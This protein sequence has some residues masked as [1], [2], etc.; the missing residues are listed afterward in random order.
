MDI[1]VGKYCRRWIWCNSWHLSNG[2]TYIWCSAI[3]VSVF[4]DSTLSGLFIHFRNLSPSFLTTGIL[5][6]TPSHSTKVWARWGTAGGKVAIVAPDP[7]CLLIVTQPLQQ[8]ACPCWLLTKGRLIE[9]SCVSLLPQPS[10]PLAFCTR[11]FKRHANKSKL[12]WELYNFIKGKKNE[13]VLDAI[14]SFM[15]SHC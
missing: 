7:H 5:G 11:S 14:P 2:W 12:T 15:Q 13:L 9:N 8:T 1:L 6:S 10:P 4:C 3:S